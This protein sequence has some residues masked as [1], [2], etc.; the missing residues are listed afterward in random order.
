MA[1]IEPERLKAIL[2]AALRLDEP[3]RTAYLKA[4]WRGDPVLQATIEQLIEGSGPLENFLAETPAKMFGNTV[5]AEHRSASPA[6]LTHNE[7]FEIGR[8]IGA[9]GSAQVFEAFDKSL[10]I[11]VALKVLRDLHPDLLDGFKRGWRSVST[12]SH[13]NLCRIYQFIYDE[14]ADAWLLSMELI[15]GGPFDTYLRANPSRVRDGFF[16]LAQAIQAL[17]VASICHGDVKPSNVLVTREGRVVALDF[18]LSNRLDRARGRELTPAALTPK[19]AAPELFKGGSFSIASD[20]YSVGVMLQDFVAAPKEAPEDLVELSRRMVSPNPSLRPGGDEIVQALAPSPIHVHPAHCNVLFVGREDETRQLQS[21]LRDRVLGGCLEVVHI[22]GA[23]GIG[24]S[25]F[26][27][28]AVRRLAATTPDLRVFS[29][30]CYEGESVPFKTIDEVVS[31]LASM[32]AALPANEARVLLPSRPHRLASLFPVFRRVLWKLDVPQTAD[33]EPAEL[34]ESRRM[35]SEAFCELIS[36]IA[37][38]FPLAIFIDDV[39]WGDLDSARLLQEVIAAGPPMLLMFAY[40]TETTPANE[41]LELLRQGKFVSV[42]LDPLNLEESRTL[43][44][45]LMENPEDTAEIAREAGGNPFFLRQLAEHRKAGGSAALSRVIEARTASLTPLEQR[46]LEVLAIARAPLSLV[47]LRDAAEL[48]EQVR[49]VQSG[50]DSCHLIRSLGTADEAVLSYHDRIAEVVG[51]IIPPGR[52][53]DIHMRIALALESSGN[54]DTER[55]ATH[56]HGAG[57]IEDACRLGRVA[58]ERAF[59]ALA[60]EQAASLYGKVLEWAALGNILLS[61]EVAKI[62]EARGHALVNCGRGLEATRAFQRAIP[63]TSPANATLLRLR[64]AS[65]LLRAGEI[66]EG[67]AATES[68]LREQGLPYP[69]TRNQAIALYLRERLRLSWNLFLFRF[70]THPRPVRYDGSPLDVCWAAATGTS[71]VYPLLAEIYFAIY[72]RLA[73]NRGDS[74]QLAL[75][76]ASHASRLAYVDDG[77]VL[78]ARAMLARANRYA[79]VDGSPYV[80]ALASA[81]S[82]TI[83]GLNG[84]WRR[85]LEE[86]TRSEAVF[87]SQCLG[88]AW[89]ISTVSTYLFTS[90]TM[91]G[92]WA[93]NSLRLFEF[94]QWARAR[95]DRYAEVT[96]SFVSAS[97][98]HHL[99]ADRPD[100]AEREIHDHLDAWPRGEQFDIQQLYAFQSLVNLDL[101]RGNSRSAWDRVCVMWP[102]VQ[103]SGLLRLTLLQTFLEDSRARAALALAQLVEGDE[104]KRLT[105]IARRV[106]RLLFRSKAR[107]AA[108]L[109]E[110]LEAGIALIEG[111]SQE[112]APHL[113]KAERSF[114]RSE[115]IPWLAVTRLALSELLKGTE[116]EETLQAGLAWMK[117][118]NIRRPECLTRMLFPL[119]SI[120]R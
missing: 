5:E 58:A 83:E 111:R 80:R 17:H 108:G 89:E 73:L 57:A 30:R 74:G 114:E 93:E 14:D 46:S 6:P 107:Y 117:S 44:C 66:K 2:D 8:Q 20:W 24:K 49:F 105:G 27:E 52:R 55:I 99:A 75:A 47:V 82:A 98:T 7:H 37:R 84:N 31:G 34:H 67:L 15:D 77:H 69:Q 115:V 39:Q 40:R 103:S 76:L 23:S 32:I 110:L 48:G 102:K 9:G 16:Q 95:G 53:R 72:L 3:D 25:A 56:F 86:A 33:N 85:C 119:S 68:L 13:P 36:K 61:A 63:L 43:A 59:T 4:M 79:E 29:G 12:L 88:V 113:R 71:M 38:R 81:M 10:G 28:H 19:Y 42:T 116:Q 92:E 50:L 91:L 54:P 65:E 26:A 35:A 112:V 18:G 45:A 94:L 96:I 64:S 118:Q 101:Y 62:Q 78:E 104:R 109:A 51:E 120:L 87:K 41:G 97:Y 22:S 70:Q 1:N 90:R 21:A 100:L 11:Q 60:F 106:S